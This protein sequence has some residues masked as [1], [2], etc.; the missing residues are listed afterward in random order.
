MAI[1]GL[2]QAIVSKYY[3]PTNH[4]GSRI[5]T[6]TGAGHVM[7]HSWNYGLD[8]CENHYVAAERHAAD[9]GWLS[10][11]ERLHGGSIPTGYCWI[12]P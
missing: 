2:R 1:H 12:L 11:T 6:E 5:K 10:T 9:L 8:P 3:G 7:W 4:R